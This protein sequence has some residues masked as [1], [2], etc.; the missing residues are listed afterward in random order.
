MFTLTVGAEPQ[1]SVSTGVVFGLINHTACTRPALAAAGSSSA[2]PYRALGRCQISPSDPSAAFARDRS[3]DRLLEPARPK[4]MSSAPTWAQPNPFNQP[5]FKGKCVAWSR[6]QPPRRSA[7]RCPT[8]KGEG[9]VHHTRAVRDD[10]LSPPETRDSFWV[11]LEATVALT[12]SRPAVDAARPVIW[13]NPRRAGGWMGP[14]GH[15][16]IPSPEGR[17]RSEARAEDQIGRPLGARTRDG[18]VPVRP[19]ATATRRATPTLRSTSSRSRRPAT[20]R[21]A[22]ALRSRPVG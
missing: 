18:A 5:R 3:T 8:S 15:D 20:S 1:V 17:L 4:T 22:S 2:A 9:T 6:V 13:T 21:G 11:T 14:D 19:I 10:H 12:Y 16:A 7:F